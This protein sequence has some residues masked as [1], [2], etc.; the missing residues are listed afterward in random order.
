M[1]RRG[2]TPIVATV[3]LI[4][5]V[6]ALAVIVFFWARGFLT[7][8]AQK[9]ERAVTVSCAGVDFEAEVV[10]NAAECATYSGK[11][12]IDI[13]N[14]GNIPIYGVQVLEYN[15]NIGNIDPVQLSDQPFVGGTIT[16]GKSS[17]VCL[18]KD[19]VDEDAFRIVPK[20][21]AEQED[22]KVVYTCPEKDGITVAYVSI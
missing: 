18:N 22:K 4:A 16:I 19:V 15:E 14:I 1:N 3:L 12:A 11:S 17:Y 5:I 13:N 21:L 10:A 9:G 7:E 8:S 2:V 6:V 20:L